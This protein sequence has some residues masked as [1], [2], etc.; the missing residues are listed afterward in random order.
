MMKF[1]SNTGWFLVQFKPNCHH[2]AEN[3]LKQQGFKTFLP[4]LEQ[5][6]RRASRFVNALN[7]LFPGYMFVSFNLKITKWHKIN[8]TLGIS[9]LVCLGDHP[10]PVPK[11]LISNIMSRCDQSGIMKPVHELNLGEK[12]KLLIGP[13]T[14]FVAEV[15]NIDS[16]KRVWVLLDFMMQPTRVHVSAQQIVRV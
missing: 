3:N 7:P 16:Q 2:I 4:L 6:K 1:E 11:K 9:R 15:E 12:V 13:F 14:N 5:T 10:R 8:G